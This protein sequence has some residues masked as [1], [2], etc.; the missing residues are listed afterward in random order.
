MEKIPAT[1]KIDESP[2]LL[3]PCAC[4]ADPAGD[5]A[6]W[7]RCES[8]TALADAGTRGLRE[9]GAVAGSTGRPCAGRKPPARSRGI[10]V[11]VGGTNTRAIRY[12]PDRRLLRRADH[13][14]DQEGLDRQR[15]RQLGF[16][17]RHPDR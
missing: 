1:E 14:G 11:A 7:R 12:R 9:P 3:P 13:A 8:A 15:Q 6:R 2:T 17:I 5:L 4:P 10:T 16:S